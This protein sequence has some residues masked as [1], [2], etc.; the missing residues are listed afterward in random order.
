MP[1]NLKF[2]L[3]TTYPIVVVNAMVIMV[4]ITV[5]ITDINTARK[6]IARSFHKNWYAAADSSAGIIWYP[7]DRS[8]SSLVIE[9]EKTNR[10]GKMQLNP[11]IKNIML[12]TI[13]VDFLI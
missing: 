10:S 3:E 7:P 6:I 11:K 9:I 5:T 4:P 13:L 2:F 8:A 1:F 12:N